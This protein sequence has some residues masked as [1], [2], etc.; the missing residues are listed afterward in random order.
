MEGP[1]GYQFVGRT[2]QMWN[3]YRQTKD[4]VDGKPWLLRFFDQ[5]RFY[6]VNESELLTLRNDF[7]TGQFKLRVEETTFSLKQYNQFLQQNSTSIKAFKARQ[8]TAFEAERERWKLNGQAEYV[9]EDNLEESDAQSE[10]DMPEGACAVGSH[11]TGTVWKLLVK[12]GQHVSAGDSLV[13][14][15]SM[16]MEFS[17]DATANGTVKQISCKEGGYVSTGQ[18]L[19]VIQED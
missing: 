2:V 15:E 10:L 13:V 1:G 18:M 4:F 17:V 11:V 3:R 7:I 8:Q 16:K 5:I 6:P 19:L 12:E 9:S 14:I